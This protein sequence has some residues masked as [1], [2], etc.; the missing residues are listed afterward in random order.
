MCVSDSENMISSIERWI[1]V[2]SLLCLHHYKDD[3]I[4][5]EIL[6]LLH[7]RISHGRATVFLKVKSHQGEPCNE[8]ADRAADVG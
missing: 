1:G 8:L 6:E 2:G 3:D 4:H 7:H 5:L